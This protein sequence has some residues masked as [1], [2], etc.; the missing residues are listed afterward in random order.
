MRANFRS[1]RQILPRRFLAALF[2]AHALLATCVAPV[3]AQSGGTGA[4]P[5]A[6]APGTPA[7]SYGLSDVDTINL[8]SGRVNVRLPLMNLKGR[9]ETGVPTSLNVNSPSLWHVQPVYPGSYYAVQPEQEVTGEGVINGMYGIKLVGSGQGGPN[10]CT[11]GGAIWATTLTRMFVVEPD[12]TEHPMRDLVNDGRP[13]SQSYCTGVGGPSRGRVFVSTDGSGITYVADELYRDGVFEGSE[14]PTGGGD[15]GWLL[16]GD[17]RR[18]RIT[19]GGNW[20]GGTMVRDRNG[21]WADADEDSLGRR[22]YGNPTPLTS[23]QCLALGPGATPECYYLA[24]KGWGGTER[25]VHIG[26]ADGYMLTG[27][28]HLVVLP[29]NQR[30]RLYYNQYNDL[31]RLDLPTG[32]SI[33]YDYGPGIGG[34]QP[35]YPPGYTSNVVPG[36]YGSFVY[37]RVTERRLYR[38]GHVLESRQTISQPEYM[39]DGQ[40]FNDGY[41]ETKRYDG[42]NNLLGSERHYFY[43]S[44]SKSHNIDVMSSAPW[45]DGREYH[46]VVYDADGDVLM[47][48][49]HE[50]QQRAPVS[51]WTGNPDEAPAN[52]PRIWQTTTWLENGTA[53][54]KTFGYD[55]AVPYNSLTDIYE[56]NYDGRLLRHTKTT[57]LKNQNGVDYTGVNLYTAANPQADTTPYMRD[58][59]L[60]VSVT[61]ATGYDRQRTTYEYDNYTPD[62]GGRHA[63]LVNYDDISGLCTWFN[64]SRQCVNTNPADGANPSSYK[65]RG[66]VTAVS[67]W[68][69]D[70]AGNV[71]GDPLTAYMQYDV[72]GNVVRAIDE[73]G[74]VSRTFYQDRFGVPDGEAQGHTQP[75][76]WLTAGRSYAFGTQAVD[77]KG[78]TA[79]TQFDYYTGKGVDSEDPN[80]TVTSVSYDDPFDR[81]T[82]VVVAANDNS[83]NSLRHRSAYEY[84]DALRVVKSFEDQNAEN[85][86]AFRREDSYDGLGRT[87]QNR[88]YDDASA[89]DQFLLVTTDYDAMGRAVQISNPYKPALDETPAFKVVEYDYL[90]RVRKAAAPGSRPVTSEY[91][92]N[93]ETV[94]DEAD[95]KRT[96][97]KDA[98]GRMVQVV[99]DPGGYGYVTD[100]VYDALGNLRKVRQASAQGAQER[101]FAYDSLGRLVRTSNPEQ[102]TNASLPQHTDPITGREQWATAYSYDVLNGTRT[103]T[104]PRG[105]VTT[106]AYDQLGRV[107]SVSHTNDPANTPTVTYTYDAADVP[108]SK[109]RVTSITSSASTYRYTGYDALGRLTGSAQVTEGQTY[110]MSYG[111]DLAGQMTSETYPS[112]RVLTTAYDRAG[113]VTGVSGLNAGQTTQYMSAVKYWSSGL[114]REAH[115]G[116]GLVEHNI[117]NE[118]QQATEIALGTSNTDSSVLK[119]EYAYGVAGAAGLVDATKNNGSVQGQKITVPGIASPLTQTYTYDKLKRLEAAQ[120]NGGASWKQTFAYDPYGNRSVDAANTTA[121]AVGENPQISAVTNRIVPRAGEFYRY[122]KAGNLDRGRLGAAYTYDA[123]GHVVA[124]NGGAAA[125][126]DGTDYAFDGLG[127]RVKKSDQYLTTVFVYDAMGRIVAEYANAAPAG[128]GTSYVTADALGTPRVVTGATAAVK[129]RHDYLPFGEEIGGPQVGLKGGR[130]AGQMYVADSVRQKFTGKE[131]DA[132]R[133]LDYFIARDYAG[134][135]GRFTSPDPLMRSMNPA[136]PQSLNRYAYVQNNP[137]SFVDPGGLERCSTEYSY[138]QCGGAEA[139]RD[140]RFGDDNASF[141]DVPN[142]SASGRSQLLRHETMVNNAFY[143]GDGIKLY[144]GGPAYFNI[145]WRLYDDGTLEVEFYHLDGGTIGGYNPAYELA[146]EM[147]RRPIARTFTV[148]YVTSVVAGGTAGAAVYAAPATFAAENAAFWTG[149]RPAVARAVANSRGYVT[150]NQT[151]GGRVVTTTSTVVGIL[152]RPAAQRMLN[153]ASEQF[154]KNAG[155]ALVIVGDAVREGATLIQTE[156]PILIQRGVQMQTLYIR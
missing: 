67:R 132:E 31:A 101:Y 99:E 149:V 33:E 17:G 77:A 91:V 148:L 87:T 134:G 61:D 29:N 38:E 130:G 85:D 65:T 122:D 127:Q 155:R 18:Y 145:Y 94:T 3:L 95:N 51:W 15:G 133:G 106:T 50:W 19:S 73:Q 126:G 1:G 88:H 7:G 53:S 153:Y 96:S 8:Y 117:F 105:V 48:V 146:K 71:V 39:S 154:A 14:Y 2:C 102:E 120:E 68:L 129:A 116:N 21:N 84:D 40:L 52:D 24:Y 143:G 70:N 121:D 49:A 20:G 114:V 23:S 44:V 150:L 90:G 142:L 5:L 113:G 58:L 32:G 128:G 152:S 81:P 111:Y 62:A 156:A 16:F 42:S 6:I 43:G 36:F 144:E 78:F 57:Y 110:A 34:E 86:R 30:Y 69:L 28:P 27:L 97:T 139:F 80:G 63:P 107:K 83:A 131:R 46:T 104:D 147:N 59:P 55:P 26:L 118:R 11:S 135:H 13:F 112:G 79:Y 92:G 125:G 98:L 136:N 22:V 124:L 10:P 12:G 25:R 41:V 9:G 66:N 64:S 103:A 151:I 75:A 109:G 60:Q 100:Y 76:E 137:T 115:L 35:T 138:E 37:R 4:T 140:N 82:L 141:R 123:D 119:L 93:T 108:N 74:N 54:V 47:Q 45:R 72:A 56:Y 89:P